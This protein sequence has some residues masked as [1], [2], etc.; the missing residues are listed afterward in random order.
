MAMMGTQILVTQGTDPYRNLAIEEYLLEQVTAK[1]IVLYLWQNSRTVVIGRN[2]NPWK[3]CQVSR[4]EEDGGHLA[5]RLSGGGAVYH[6]LGNLN[7]TFLTHKTDYDLNL[8]LQVV[9]EAVRSL[10]LGACQ[11]GRNDLTVDGR[12]FSGS[13]F[14]HSRQ[15][16]C[17]HGTLL[18]DTNPQDMA[19]YLTVSPDKLKAKGVDSVRSRVVNLKE[20]AP[21]LDVSKARQALTQAMERVYPG[22]VE[23]L[24]DAVLPQE[25]IGRRTQRFASRQWRFQSPM[26][27]AYEFSR[28]FSWGDIQLRLSLEGEWVKEAQVF[29]DALDW[30]TV[31]QLPAFLRG[32]HFSPAGLAESIAPLTEKNPQLIGELQDALTRETI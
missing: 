16:V 9:L 10:G 7:F 22:R 18:I 19:R 28:R 24:T 6:D 13:A 12:K 26:A 1:T 21:G 29:S 2:Q 23:Y 27:F 11:T 15:G 20:L 32:A 5:R 3:E 25:E 14:F 17:H 8:Q 4:L 30:Q 31:E